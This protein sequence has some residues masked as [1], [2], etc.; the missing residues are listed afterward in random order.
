MRALLLCVLLTLAGCI[1]APGAS[2]DAPAA[3]TSALL[4]PLPTE[5]TGLEP[6]S[7]VEFGA[8]NDMAFWGDTVFVATHNNGMHIVD[9]K[10]PLAPKEL[11]VI[12]C[13]GKDAGV[14]QIGSRI[15]VT[16]S[17]QSDDKCPDAAPKGG[18]R[19]VDV[20]NA[21]A[22][23]V[24]SQVPLKYGSHTHTPYGNTGILYNSAY[25]LASNPTA[26]PL[27]H[28]R[29]EIVNI[30]N[31][32]TPVVDGEFLFPQTSGSI[33]CH[34]ILAE[35]AL[36]RAICGGISETM[37]WDVTDL[38]APKVIATIVNPK[39]SIH[40]SAATTRNG[41]LLALGDEYAGVLAPACHPASTAPTG[42]I[43]FYDLS[44]PT[45]PKELGFV[46]PPAGDPGTV[47][48]AHNFNWVD[49]DH[50]VS[51]FYS[52]GTLLIDASDPAH[53][54]TMAQMQQAPTSSW[55]S[56][57]YRGAVFS[58]DGVRGLDIYR[59]V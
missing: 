59:L 39:I 2:V 37:I 53:P 34:D 8:G 4:L 19:L 12:D 44:D 55:A 18:I 42:A 32:D 28:H 17:S 41:T 50:L 27:D 10:D 36:H 43:W 22:P 49:D 31:P 3:D 20:T 29:S 24:L 58:G 48:T 26:S 6:V 23:V 11:A 9:V 35:P 38:H 52:G 15:I 16:L 40:H 54:V 33:G 21:S 5:I 1:Q 51:G 30:S 14:S 47:C 46:P 13:N 45:S 57:A 56:Y 25:N 7:N